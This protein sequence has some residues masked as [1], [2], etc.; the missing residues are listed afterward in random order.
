MSFEEFENPMNRVNRMLE[1]IDAGTSADRGDDV[2]WCRAWRDT[3]WRQGRE[4][5]W[6]ADKACRRV[7]NSRADEDDKAIARRC[8]HLIRDGYKLA[9]RVDEVDRELVDLYPADEARRRL[10]EE[11]GWE[12]LPGETDAQILDRSCMKA[13]A[14]N[15]NPHLVKVNAF[16]YIRA[17]FPTLEIGG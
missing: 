10:D 8:L 9:L 2:R 16:A 6:E 4:K 5:L 11:I 14:A 1:V 15:P 13:R 7:I 12:N 17:R 3:L